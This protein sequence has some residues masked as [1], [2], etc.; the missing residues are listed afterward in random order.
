MSTC[1]SFQLF[2]MNFLA[3]LALTGTSGIQMARLIHNLAQFELAVAKLCPK[4]QPKSIN[5]FRPSWSQL[6]RCLHNFS[7]P[8]CRITLETSSTSHLPWRCLNFS[9]A[10]IELLLRQALRVTCTCMGTRDRHNLGQ[11]ELTQREK[12]EKKHGSPK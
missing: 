4:N 8:K 3:H 6:A 12:I 2:S 9:C 5:S 10:C 1:P 11:N 7:R